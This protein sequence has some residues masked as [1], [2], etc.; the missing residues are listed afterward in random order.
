MHSASAIERIKARVSLARATGLPLAKLRIGYGKTQGMA[1]PLIEVVKLVSCKGFVLPLDHGMGASPPCRSVSNLIEAPPFVGGAFCLYGDQIRCRIAAKT[2][3]RWQRFWAH[4]L[5]EF[6]LS[7]NQAHPCIQ[8]ERS[9]SA[10]RRSASRP[11]SVSRSNWYSCANGGRWFSGKNNVVTATP[12]PF[13]ASAKATDCGPSGS[14]FPAL[15]KDG[16]N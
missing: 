2:A 13:S 9:H 3:R 4:Q 7:L 14:A 5:K 16:G 15:M 6:P 12:C 1:L 8:S 10:E 11:A